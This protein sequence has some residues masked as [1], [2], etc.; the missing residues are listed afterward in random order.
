LI[1]VLG[2]VLRAVY[3]SQPMRND[4]AATYLFYVRKPPLY[5]LVS[6]TLPNN[7]VLHTLLASV[8]TF[9]FG[10][11]PW[12]IRL[13]AFIAG[14]AMIPLAYVV[15][16]RMF[17]VRTGLLAA[18]LV[19][20]SSVLIELSTNARGYTM[21]AAAFLALLAIAQQLPDSGRWKRFALV[22]ALG[23]F[24]IPTMLF[25]FGVV[26]GWLGLRLRHDRIA[27]RL[28]GRTVVRTAVI[29]VL[30]YLPAL[31]WTG[32]RAFFANRFVASEP[33]G[34]FVRAIGPLLG[35]MW[36]GW[37]RNL[38]IGGAV[39]FAVFFAVGLMRRPS[40]S[41]VAAAVAWCGVLVLAERWVPFSRVWSFLIPVYW[42]VVAAGI[43]VVV[44]RGSAVIAVG[45]CVAVGVSVL[46]SGSVVRSRDTGYFPDAERVAVALRGLGP[47]A[48]YNPAVVP[49]RYY[50]LLHGKTLPINA[51]DVRY[52]VVDEAAGQSLGLLEN[53]LGL[54]AEHAVTFRHFPGATVYR[55]TGTNP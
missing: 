36:S 20:S 28:L 33:F 29:T 50:A 25:P 14:V 6:Y 51:G 16:E 12:A 31:L 38:T 13:P 37:N 39:L 40:S 27:L 55:L 23:F 43:A 17:E 32:P 54:H 46:V 24:T 18:A 1:T 47:L 49:L 35:H 21:V 10:N 53:V 8:S 2:V 22:A 4:E 9:I 42:I 34:A 7:H 11:H 30:L 26:V 52:L 44:R 48:A 19:A 41:L 5:G 45:L 15:A 3:L